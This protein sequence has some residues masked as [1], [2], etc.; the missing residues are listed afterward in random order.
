M[1]PLE[2]ESVLTFLNHLGVSQYEIH[3]KIGD[4]LRGKLESDIQKVDLKSSNG[5]NVLLQLLKSSWSYQTDT[6]PKEWAGSSS[7]SSSI[8]LLP[9]AQ[10]AL[11]SFLK[12]NASNE[13]S[14]LC[15]LPRFFITLNSFDRDCFQ[16]YSS[17]N[18]MMDGLYCMKNVHI[19]NSIIVR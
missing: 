16:A 15:Q 18:G 3:K 6:N 2:P 4:A 8:L 9:L 5:K 17:R 1:E 10:G 12:P 19:M 13:M 11:I 14:L 7:S